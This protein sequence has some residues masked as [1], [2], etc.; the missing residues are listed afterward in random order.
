M[1][2]YVFKEEF[3]DN[4][5]VVKDD[6]TEA[7]FLKQNSRF[8]SCLRFIFIQTCVWSVVFVSVFV[9]KLVS[10]N[11]FETIKSGYLSA[12]TQEDISLDKLKEWV[13]DFF[14][15]ENM[16]DL[17]KNSGSISESEGSGGVDEITNISQND[18]VLTTKIFPPS[19]GV[20]TSGFGERIHPITKTEGFHTGIDIASKLNTP[21]Y[22]AFNGVVYECGNNEIYG[23]Y[24]I[25]KHS[26]NLFTFYGHC[27]SVRA[28]EGMRMRRGEVIA[29]MGSTGYSTGPHLHFEIRING[30]RVNPA[31][32]LKGFG[33]IE[34]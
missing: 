6:D 34:F 23:N 2:E 19:T 32:V 20:V 9:L 18:F 25:I 16:H 27:N 28:R 26:E 14:S 3:L 10:P 29:Q 31:F 8:E 12:V 33:E 15:K 24:I 17:T 4:I 21:I 1:S 5:D 11:V 30:K 13:C 7:I 22:C